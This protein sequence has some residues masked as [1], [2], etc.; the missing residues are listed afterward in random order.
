MTRKA[1]E[2]WALFLC[3]RLGSFL[4]SASGQNRSVRLASRPKSIGIDL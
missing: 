2:A 3:L 4:R 1:H